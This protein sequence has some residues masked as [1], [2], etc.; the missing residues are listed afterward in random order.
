MSPTG[1]MLVALLAPADPPRLG[2][3]TELTYAGTVTEAVDRPGQRFRR[4]H[5]LEVRVLVL[6]R[7]PGFA[8]AA[9]LTLL[10]RSDADR[11]GPPAVRLD[12]VR[13]PDDGP[14]VRL[15]PTG[16]APLR[17][18]HAPAALI[19]PPPLDSFAPA[20]FGWLPPAGAGWEPAGFGFVAAERCE[21]SRRAEAAAGWDQPRGGETAWRR[22]EAVWVSARDG[23]AR[24]VHRTIVQ[25]DGVGP[26][27]AVLIET[28]Y[29]LK[30]QA[31]LIGRTLD[32]YR[33]EVEVAA[34][35]A[36]GLAGLP[37][38]ALDARLVELAAYLERTDPGTPYR[39]AVLAARRQVEA[40]RRGETGPTGTPYPPG[41]TRPRGDRRP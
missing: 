30:G 40:V 34:T 9:V 26:A 19:P 32:R 23:A 13:I 22:D 27:P 1:L 18:A 38:R 16:P 31:R 20:E 8:D 17:L 7:R 10:R 36:D 41:P 33:D 14:A 35:A 25:R 6:D 4:A 28:R 15:A 11:A 21:E 37:P 5:D 39:E 2:R 29:A 12:L 3:G 24:R